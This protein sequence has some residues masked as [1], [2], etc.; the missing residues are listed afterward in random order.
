MTDKWH[1]YM[2]KDGHISL[3]SLNLVKC[4]Y[5]V[6]AIINSFYNVQ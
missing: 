6:D 4:A 1:M 2:T 5:L 3:A